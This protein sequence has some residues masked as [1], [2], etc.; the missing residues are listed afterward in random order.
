[1]RDMDSVTDE[2]LVARVIDGEPQLFEQ[3]MRRNNTRVYRTARSVLRDNAEAED[4]MQDAWVRAYEHLREFDGRSL[5]S[6]WLTR[7]ALHEALARVRRRRGHEPLQSVPEDDVMFHAEER[8]PEQNAT[9]GELR[10]VLERAIDALPDEFRTVFMLR[11]VEELS[12]VET[13]SCLGIPEATVKTRLH[14]AREKLR[15]RLTQDLEPQLAVAFEFLR[16]RCDRVVAGVFSR[17]GLDLALAQHT[18]GR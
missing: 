7:I 4:V 14:R 9:D 3:L 2:G 6:T 1:M 13:A 10:G 17:L 15:V 12:S 11:A 8:S 5:F 16:P 18:R